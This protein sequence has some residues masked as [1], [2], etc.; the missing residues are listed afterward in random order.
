MK[1]LVITG[2]PHKS[3]TTAALAD[4]FIKGAKESVTRLTVLTRLSRTFILA[5]RARFVTPRTAAALSRTICKR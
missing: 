3:G 5:L 1:V 2:S 4:E